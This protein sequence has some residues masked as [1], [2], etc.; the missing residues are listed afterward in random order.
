[1]YTKALPLAPSGLAVYIA[2]NSLIPESSKFPPP[3]ALLRE[4]PALFLA[5][6]AIPTVTPSTDTVT[7]EDLPGG[8]DAKAACA[9]GAAASAAQTRLT[10]VNSVRLALRKV[11][12]GR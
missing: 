3:N 8:S 12:P 4:S 11:M 6:L 5:S 1:M 10:E 9:A 7:V 2:D